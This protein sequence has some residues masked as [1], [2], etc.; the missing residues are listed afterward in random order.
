M[1]FFNIQKFFG[2]GHQKEKIF[3]TNSPVKIIMSIRE[4]EREKNKKKKNKKKNKNKKKKR[5]L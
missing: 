3:R 2:N 4:R 5:V 1:S